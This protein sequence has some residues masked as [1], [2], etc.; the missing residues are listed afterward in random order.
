L[1]E[2]GRRDGPQ[3]NKE[4]LPSGHHVVSTANPLQIQKRQNCTI[5]SHLR[6]DRDGSLL[7]MKSGN[8][9]LGAARNPDKDSLIHASI[10]SNAMD[11]EVGQ[12]PKFCSGPILS[13][14]E[15]RVPANANSCR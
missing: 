10:S 6:G 11:A 2:P 15:L 7:M 8:R 4:M 5:A 12:L 3:P 14:T 1:R 9:R 13:K